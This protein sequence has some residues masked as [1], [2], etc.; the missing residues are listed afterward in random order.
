MIAALCMGIAF[1]A[2]AETVTTGP[3]E[4]VADKFLFTEGPVWLPSGELAFSDIPKNRIYKIDKTVFREPSNNSNGLALD[5]QGR[6]I[7]CEHGSRSVTRTE[8]DGKMTTL[9]SAFEGKKLNS[10]NDVI[11]RSDGTIFFTDPPYAIKK[12]QQELAFQGVFAI[13]PDGK[14]SAIARDFN[15]PNGIGLSPDEKTL[16]VADTEGNHVRAFDLAKDGSVSNGR[17]F[18]EV[19]GPDGLKVDQKG[20]VWCT[21]KDGVRVMNP[22]GELVSTVAVPQQSANCAFGDADGKTLY[23]TARTGLYKVRCVT[24][25]LGFPPGK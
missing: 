16:Y 12:E 10:P 21:A 3:V 6:L 2:A 11:V 14:L 23:I 1:A 20:Y 22:K 19:P 15:K 18:C 8:T 17:V 4:P 13:A 24:P 5:P 25:G 9:A 7:A